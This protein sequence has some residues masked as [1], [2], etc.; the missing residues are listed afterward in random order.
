MAADFLETIPFTQIRN[1][2]VETN[3]GMYLFYVDFSCAIESFIAVEKDHP[4][5]SSR[6]SRA[7]VIPGSE[8]CA[9]LVLLYI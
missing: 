9:S 4:C 2:L 8:W 7:T 5:T 6:Y 1:V 3:A